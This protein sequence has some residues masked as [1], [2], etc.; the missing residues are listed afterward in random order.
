MRKLVAHWIHRGLQTLPSGSFAILRLL[1]LVSP[2]DAPAGDAFWASHIEPLL[3]DRCA[4]CHNPTKAKSGL[5]LSSLQTILRGGERGAAVIPGHPDESNLYKFLSSESDPHMPPGERQPLGE[6]QVALIKKWIQD[7]PVAASSRITETSTNALAVNSPVLAAQPSLKWKPPSNMPPAQV[8]DRFLEL[9]WKRDKVEP[10]KRVD[11]AGFVRRVYLDLAGRIPTPQ[12]AA[13]FMANDRSIVAMHRNHE[14][15]LPLTRPSGTLSP[16]RS[17]P[18]TPSLSP[19]EG[20]RVP[21]GRVRGTVV[22]DKRAQLIDTLLASD[23]YPRQ[24]REVFDS[25]LMTRRG[26]EWEDKRVNQKWFAFLEDAFCRNRPWNEVVRELIVA[27]PEQAED[28]GAV[29]YIYERQNNAQ[30]VAEALAPV[31]FGVQVKCAQCHDHMVAREIKQA[32]YWGMVAAFNRSKNVDTPAGPGVAES[33]IGGFASFANLKKESQPALLTFFNG[34]KVDEAWP[35]DGEKE[36]DS[37][38]LYLVPPPAKET[39]SQ[40]GKGPRRQRTV[41]ADQPAVPKFSRRVAFADAV[42]RDNPLLARAMV[43]RIW[44]M[45]F[46]RG[47]VHPVDL[48]DSKHPPSHPELL[49]WLARDFEKSGYDVKR[50]IRVLC[51]TKA[52]QLDSRTARPGKAKPA[53]ADSFARAL[54]KPLSAEQLFRSL[55]IATGNQVDAESNIG[56][57]SEKELRRA[58]VAQFPD[59]FPAEYNATLFQAMFLSNSPLFDDLLTPRGDNL[60]AR[61]PALREPEARIRLAFAAVFGREPERDELR[62]CTA[63]LAAHSPEAGVKQLLWALLSSAEFQLNH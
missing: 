55:L 48:M 37:P 39:E 40:S 46:G 54:D 42:T 27:R 29:W 7:L 50:L 19:S 26:A 9:S 10:A 52:Y 5:D 43:N 16:A 11:D 34:R 60:M 8:V 17:G 6:D 62:E 44:A 13:S 49:D 45:V 53:A 57:R 35:K 25:V 36:T 4:E 23:E 22:R 21:E 28:R 47:L 31:V 30:A 32:H 56:G 3:K 14:P 59:V 1:L 15:R 24:M 2:L 18:L 38:E 63:H 12:E 61:L 33:A 51:N 58:F 20:E 41:K